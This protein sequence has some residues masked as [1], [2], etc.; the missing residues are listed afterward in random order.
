M[1]EDFNEEHNFQWQ[2]GTNGRS[3]GYL[4]LYQGGTKPSGYKSFC[5]NPVYC[6]EFRSRRGNRACAV[7]WICVGTGVKKGEQKC[8]NQEYF[9][10]QKL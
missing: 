5:R 3:G 6:R 10:T 7:N 8:Q 1:I 9:V 2:T 4:V